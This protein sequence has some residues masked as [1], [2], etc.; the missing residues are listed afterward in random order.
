MT[1]LPTWGSGKGTENPQ[2]IWL[3]RPVGFDYRTSTGLG[4]QTLRGHKQNLVPGP[5][6][7]EQCPHRRVSQ[8]C[9][10]VSRSIQWRHGLTVA[11][12][13]LRGTEYNSTGRHK[14]FWR[15]CPLPLPQF[16][17]RPNNREG[18]QPCP[19]TEDWIK[20]LLSMGLPIRTR[21][22]SPSQLV[23]PIRKLPQ[24]SY[25]SPSEG[26]QTENHDHRKWTHVITWTTALSNSVKLW[27]MGH[28]GEFWQNVVHWRREWQ[29]T[30]VFLP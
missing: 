2:W 11:C 10:W 21:L 16:G 19:S 24:A 28:G 30:S 14:S 15:R 29:T 1:G 3:W 27:E 6:R 25:S 13:G 23:S 5:T 8:T 17:L 7:K 12:C 20:D 22:R 26:R 9:L 18:T 4:K